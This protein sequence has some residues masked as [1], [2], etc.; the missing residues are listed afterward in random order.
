MRINKLAALFIIVII[1]SPNL[2][3]VRGQTLTLG[4]FDVD[5]EPGEDLSISGT[6]TAEANLT[7]IIVF[8]LT[9]IYE[10]N[11]TAAGDGNYTEDYGI[12][13]N[14]TEGV[15]SVT[16]SAGGSPGP[17]ASSSTNSTILPRVSSSLSSTRMPALIV[18]L[19]V[20]HVPI[21]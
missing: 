17:F 19:P 3:I 18:A 20:S 13:G 10:V 21:A 15:Y 1:V 9:A 4:S 14:A 12:P 2:T 16:V 5:Y 7:L 8:N 6:A 11:F